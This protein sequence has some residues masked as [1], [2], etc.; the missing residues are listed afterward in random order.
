MQPNIIRTD[1]RELIKHALRGGRNTFVTGSA[2]SGKTFLA[3]EF[4][5]EEEDLERLE[6]ALTASTGV[7]AINIGGETIHRFSGIGHCNRTAEIDQVVAM[8]D[9]RSRSPKPW[10]RNKYEAL[11]EA[12]TIVID[13]VSMIRRDQLEL[14]DGVLRQTRG[15]LTSPF[16]GMQVVLVG[17]FFQLPPVVTGT[18]SRAFQ[19]LKTKP[20]CFQS[21]LWSDAD[22]QGFELTTQFRQSETDFLSA[23]E[24]IR[25]GRVSESV[26]DLFMSR[27]GA[28]LD[29][30]LRPVKLYPR[31]K[32]VAA[33]NL[34]C[35]TALKG[36]FYR[37]RALFAGPKYEI[38]ALKKEVTAHEVFQ[39]KIGAQVMALVN[40]MDGA[41]VNGSMGIITAVSD[42]GV[43]VEWADGSSCWVANNTWE[44]TV[45]EKAGGRMEKR[46]TASMIQLP[47]TLAYATTIH[48]SQG[49][50]LDLVDLD[51]TGCFTAGQVY[52]ALSRV[53]TLTGLRLKRWDPSVISA[54][55]RVLQ[56]YGVTR[57]P[58]PRLEV[59]DEHP[60]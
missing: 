48:K 10:H 24:E 39:F 21:H 14:I 12:D 55:K 5:E 4:R 35:V 20:F 51:P 27:V 43:F 29:T 6:V 28:K 30:Q 11:M 25:I 15:R 54:D 1:D 32:E 52:V 8:W 50:T 57:R 31:R 13:E 7:A 3:A 45:W 9:Q 53:R 46:R 2:G 44:R 26:H 19:D 23:L 60:F 59:P 40:D 18:E 16:G 36:P 42:E 22:I 56:F 58:R 49:L 41:Y 37:R 38:E 47:L 34:A 17:D 33:E